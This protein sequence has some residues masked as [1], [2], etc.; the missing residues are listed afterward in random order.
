MIHVHDRL[1]FFE[2][3]HDSLSSGVPYERRGPRHDISQMWHWCEGRPVTRHDG[4]GAM[5]DRIGA[6]VHARVVTV[7]YRTPRTYEAAHAR[8][9]VALD[10]QQQPQRLSDGAVSC[11]TVHGPRAGIDETVSFHLGPDWLAAVLATRRGTAEDRED[12]GA[13]LVGVAGPGAR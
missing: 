6:A 7:A 3:C 9:G 2:K 8:L 13:K 4:S 12:D 10:G 1:A 5:S 11:R